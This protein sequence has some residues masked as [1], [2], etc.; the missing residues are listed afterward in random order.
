MKRLF[1]NLKKIDNKP[2]GMY[3][4]L[5]GKYKSAGLTLEILHV[6]G[7]AFAAPSRIRVALDLAEVGLG[8][9]LKREDLYTPLSDFFH[10]RF[11]EMFDN[12][13]NEGGEGGS[14]R[15]H[16]AAPLQKVLKR[17]ACI[18]ENGSVVFYLAVGLPAEKRRV[19]GDVATQI[20]TADIPD[21]AM[22]A[23]T[24]EKR[25][26]KELQKHLDLYSRQQRI[27][28]WMSEE[29]LV[30][31]VANDSLLPRASGSSDLPLKRGVRFESPK[32]LE[33]TYSDK[34]GELKGMGIKEGV[35]LITGGA[36]HGKS[37]LLEALE[38][39]VYNHI[40][41]D[42]REW[43]LCENTAFKLRSDEGRYVGGVNINTFLESLPG[44]VDPSNFSTT[45]ASGSTSQATATIEAL[46]TGSKTMLID[47]DQCAVNFLLRDT[48]M[49]KLLGKEREGLMPL[50]GVLPQLR[51]RKVSLVLCHGA[52]GE[53]LDQADTVI[54]MK[55]WKVED[56]TAEA[57]E[58]VAELP[59]AELVESKIALPEP[60][61]SRTIVAGYPERDDMF[62]RPKVRGQELSWV[63]D[64][65]DLRA[66]TQLVDSAQMMGVGWWVQRLV[67]R[68]LDA[69]AALI[70]KQLRKRDSVVKVAR[71][72]GGDVIEPR[73]QEV[74]AAVHRF[75]GL[76]WD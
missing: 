6:Q 22:E 15:I 57:K 3:R 69:D 70:N 76:E 73:V 23:L 35:T 17:T 5:K 11:Y 14:G 46:E 59:T 55:D 61:E 12:Y 62:R 63:R 67:I 13:E 18:I 29:G 1:L 32:T 75:K 41:R 40:N 20:L 26:K 36:Y 34:E 33:V 8:D 25:E 72:W 74:W 45:R 44:T 24:L 53:Y 43:V 39:G 42:G 48:R 30:A 2:Y 9:Y 54:L 16:I 49:L 71:T 47:E 10:R 31:F 28:E 38:N 27:R 4:S 65:M 60:S 51:K 58:L 52:T 50:L 64:G 56:I 19:L 66:L 21:K 37:T 7:D 68:E